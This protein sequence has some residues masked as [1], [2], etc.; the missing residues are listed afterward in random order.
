MIK[1]V[2]QIRRYQNFNGLIM[3]R[4]RVQKQ[5][6]KV[7]QKSRQC[8]KKYFPYDLLNPPNSKVQDKLFLPYKNHLSLSYYF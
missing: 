5:D 2:E 7:L 8:K 6:K 3:S 1:V 4:V